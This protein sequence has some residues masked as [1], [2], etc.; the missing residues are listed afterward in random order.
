MVKM[1]EQ[2]RRYTFKERVVLG[3]V[4]ATSLL[5]EIYGLINTYQSPREKEQ[6]EEKYTCKSCG[7]PITK[8]MSTDSDLK[9]LCVDCW[10]VKNRIGEN[11]V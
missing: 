4:I 1:S 11:N 9:G 3:F 10:E 2:K 6:P 8:S 5:G 7:D